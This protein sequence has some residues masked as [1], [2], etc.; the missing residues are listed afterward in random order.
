MWSGQGC[1]RTSPLWREAIAEEQSELPPENIQMKAAT[2]I[3]KDIVLIFSALIVKVGYRFCAKM[4]K[5][6]CQ[7]TA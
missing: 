1:P 4:A 5:R 3:A 7:S 6:F 2:S